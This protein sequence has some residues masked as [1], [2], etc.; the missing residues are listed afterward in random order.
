MNEISFGK[1]CV[2]MFGPHKRLSSKQE[3]F[4]IQTNE[5]YTAD[6]QQRTANPPSRPWGYDVPDGDTWQKKIDTRLGI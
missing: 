2:E 3:S 6:P 1:A 4:A 5:N